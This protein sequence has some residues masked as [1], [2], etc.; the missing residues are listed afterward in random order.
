MTTITI[1]G[2]LTNLENQNQNLEHLLKV[3]LKGQEAMKNHLYS[4]E[5]GRFWEPK[6]HETEKDKIKFQEHQAEEYIEKVLKPEYA[7]KAEGEMMAE[8]FFDGV[9]LNW[10]KT[11]AINTIGQALKKIFLEVSVDLAKWLIDEASNLI[12]RLY[13]NASAEE[14]ETFKNKVEEVFPGNP[15][16]EKLN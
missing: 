15:L 9:V 4:D 1:D 3:L 2:R 6:G 7:K 12:V 8:G 14:K 13:N 16:L 10:L 11:Q 5:D